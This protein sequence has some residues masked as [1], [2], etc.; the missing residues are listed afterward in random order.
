V[1]GKTGATAGFMQTYAR[2]RAPYFTLKQVAETH[3]HVVLEAT[4]AEAVVP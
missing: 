3:T 1:L 2:W 4:V